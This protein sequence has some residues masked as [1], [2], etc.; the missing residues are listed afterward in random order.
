MRA[1]RTT[2]KSIFEPDYVDHEIA[3][4]LE[5]ISHWL[6]GHRELLERVA[7]DLN[8]KKVSAAVATVCRSTRRCVAPSSSS[9]AK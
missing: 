1:I 2:Q 3:R 8:P 7:Q 9:T 6:D 5:G 4:E